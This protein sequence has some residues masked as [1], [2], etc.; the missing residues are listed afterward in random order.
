M[1]RTFG[2]RFR[3]LV[4]AG[5]AAALIL[6]N[7][8][9][10]GLS[11]YAA[12]TV[13]SVKEPKDGVRTGVTDDVTLLA[14]EI[15]TLRGTDLSSTIANYEKTFLL[16]LAADFCVFIKEDFEVLES[17]AEGRVAVGGDF[18]VRNKNNSYAV[19]AGDYNTHTSLDEL[20]VNGELL[21]DRVGAA[22][23][24]LGGVLKDGKL[25]DVYYENNK[26]Y[27]EFPEHKSSRILDLN[28][29]NENLLPDDAYVHIPDYSSESGKYEPEPTPD[30]KGK[31]PKVDKTQT[32]VVKL[33]DFEEEY[34]KL[35][36]RSTQ[37]SKSGNSGTITYDENSKTIKFTYDGD[38]EDKRECIY[39]NLTEEQYYN[40]FQNATS[41]EYIN[42]PKLPTPRFVVNNDGSAGWWYNSYIVV[43]IAGN[44][45]L[46][47]ETGRNELH[48]VKSPSD[49]RNKTAFING[50]SL[51]VDLTGKNNGNNHPGVTSILYNFYEADETTDIVLGANFQG[52]ILAPKAYVTDEATLN[53]G[54]HGHLSGAL[55]AR[56]FKG[57]TEFGYRPF[58]GG[59]KLAEDTTDYRIAINKYDEED[60][61]KDNPEPLS[62]ATFGIFAIDGDGNVSDTPV[63]TM[64][65]TEEQDFIELTPGRYV[66]K[67]ISAPQGYALSEDVYY[68]EVEDRNYTVK[69]AQTANGAGYNYDVIRVYEGTAQEQTGDT[70]YEKDISVAPEETLTV[71]LPRIGIR[72]YNNDQFNKNDKESISGEYIYSAFR[73]DQRTYK[74]DG[75]EVKF[76]FY[77]GVGGSLL[78]GTDH[79]IIDGKTYDYH[80]KEFNDIYK[81]LTFINIP[82]MSS[83]KSEDDFDDDD[84]Y[85]AYVVLYKNEPIFPVVTL[86]RVLEDKGFEGFHF[87]DAKAIEVHKVDENNNP[88][89]GAE[90]RF[91]NET[92][93]VS[94]DTYSST[95]E[96]V[97]EPI[98]KWD[99]S[100]S[101][102][103]KL[104]DIEQISSADG[105]T[106]ENIYRVTEDEAPE[107]YQITDNDTVFIW[108]GDDIYINEDV[109]RGEA[110]QY[111]PVKWQGGQFVGK[112]DY[113]AHGWKKL[114]ITN[115]EN[116]VIYIR[117]AKIE[118]AKL[119]LRKVN[120]S[121]TPI[122]GAHIALYHYDPSSGGDGEL[123]EKWEPLTDEVDFATD[124]KNSNSKYVKNGYLLPGTYYLV[125]TQAP[126]GY[127]DDLVGEKL[128]FTVDEDF[129]ITKGYTD[130]GKVDAKIATDNHEDWRML[131]YQALT[132]EG[133]TRFEIQ[134]SNVDSGGFLLY[135][136][137]YNNDGSPNYNINF[138]NSWTESNPAVRLY[139]DSDKKYIYDFSEPTT[140]NLGRLEI[141]GNKMEIDYVRFY[142]GGGEMVG[143]K[144][145][146]KIEGD[147]SNGYTLSIPNETD[148]YQIGVSK[149]DVSDKFLPG[150]EI[151]LYA[152]DEETGKETKVES[153]T[154]GDGTLIFNAAAG[155]KYVVRET[156]APDGYTLSD[157]AYYFRISTEAVE[158]TV[159]STGEKSYTPIIYDSPSD[160]NSG[161]YI[162][163]E[164]ASYA[165]TYRWTTEG[166]ET[167]IY[168][169][170][171]NGNTNIVDSITFEYSDG[172]KQTVSTVFEYDNAIS[173][174]TIMNVWNVTN[175]SK[176]NE[177]VKI[178]AKIKSSSEFGRAQNAT[179]SLIMGSSWTDERPQQVTTQDKEQDIVLIEAKKGTVTKYYKKAQASDTNAVLITDPDDP[180]YGQYVEGEAAGN[181]EIDFTAP[182]ITLNIYNDNTFAEPVKASVVYDPLNVNRNTYKI[183]GVEYKITVDD[184]GNITKIEKKIEQ[185]YAEVTD[186]ELKNKFKVIAVTEEDETAEYVVFYDD[187]IVYPTF[188][189][190]ESFILTKNLPAN[191]IKDG[192]LKITDKQT[193]IR[194]SKKDAADKGKEGAGELSGAKLKL[195]LT[196]ATKTTD[197]TATLENVTVSDVDSTKVEKAKDN[198]S[199]TWESGGTPAKFTGLPDGKYTITEEAAPDEYTKLTK[200]ITFVI[201]NGIIVE[202][203]GEKVNVKD[204]GVTG[205]PGEEIV[206]KDLIEVFNEKKNTDVE[207][208]LPSTGGRGVFWFCVIGMCL[209]G[210]ALSLKKMRRSPKVK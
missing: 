114:D 133:A 86:S 145:A 169:I 119:S 47:E 195:T 122:G 42:I 155:T 67:E 204:E 129:N 30:G 26:V 181:V 33:F 31:W 202:I 183:D 132:V 198:M 12:N 141:Q 94:G 175:L 210:A 79:M 111:L 52:T 29:E 36:T 21:G 56:K 11:T 22:T 48:F 55:I 1:K 69:I 35:S 75:H 156:K 89:T 44:G 39:F 13:K 32:Y 91:E 16:G 20:L 68:F 82:N 54:D 178:T 57:K 63:H 170:A 177:V 124:L 134:F 77:D 117:N 83:Q 162:P 194:I 53:G 38:P 130:V 147:E 123:I 3:R 140:F 197:G 115:P 128:F 138:P 154:S 151:T 126:V 85:Y 73:A 92:Y 186:E 185:G 167:S 190:D 81:D 188:V 127:K 10:M 152:I 172:T 93:K 4:S 125:E 206:I 80:T 157:D 208:D 160:L 182:K 209:I 58:T 99:K 24:I 179:I 107:G 41:I 159:V 78:Q 116:R 43:N 118:G 184:G 121:G 17:D 15:S 23:V 143:T 102:T 153:K 144:S 106:Y 5:M 136:D 45:T 196:E 61:G 174:Y 65:T 9:P 168:K 49:N 163:A 203:D 37:L 105:I 28:Y 137:F 90:I 110:L 104:K 60:R 150:A 205:T 173:K 146:L 164:N 19:G 131:T 95:Y 8:P 135:R 108:C 51:H 191:I 76:R 109:P 101:S 142:T 74:I 171:H 7:L 180:A 199:I 113:T 201:E 176:P 200:S 165:Q 18:Y 96:D 62:G 84:E 161:Q 64:T 207:V 139:A 149:V 103:V 34:T 50:A 2:K 72:V 88:L 70:I 120:Q 187:E 25:S 148:G 14:G 166:S 59:V 193:E 158:R 6:S 46:N 98:W 27:E 100:S 66:L 87:F 71:T 189:T 40:W 97:V 112:D 192:G